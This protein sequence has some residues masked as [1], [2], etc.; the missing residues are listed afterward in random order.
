MKREKTTITVP[1]FQKLMIY[2]EYQSLAIGNQ[3][4]YDL[5]VEEQQV[6][7]WVYTMSL[8]N[9]NKEAEVLNFELK[10]T[11][12]QEHFLVYEHLLANLRE[13]ESDESLSEF[14]SSAQRDVEEFQENYP[15]IV[16][17]YGFRNKAIVQ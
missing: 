14:I 4:M 8:A 13:I 5:A 15:E 7:Q 2:M 17:E 6:E 3:E 1:E 12:E 11:E 16:S 10:L 9:L